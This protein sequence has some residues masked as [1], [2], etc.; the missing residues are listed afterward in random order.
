M[1]SNWLKKIIILLDLEQAPGCILYLEVLPVKIG[2]VSKQF[3]I[4]VDTLRYYDRIGL[5]SPERRGKVR[6]Y[7][8]ECCQR[9]RAIMQMKNLMFTLEEIRDILTLDEQV[10]HSI[11]GKALDHQALAAILARVRGK[12]RDV[13]NLESNIRE[14]KKGLAKIIA[15]VEKFSGEVNHDE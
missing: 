8:P 7:S 15:K 12:Y 14:V 3:N 4:P 1:M 2:A 9:L 13:E 5:L 6:W 10:E 11:E